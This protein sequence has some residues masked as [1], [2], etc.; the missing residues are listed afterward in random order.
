MKKLIKNL[1]KGKKQKIIT[2]EWPHGWYVTRVGRT[3][4]KDFGFIF[5]AIKGAYIKG[6]YSVS[7]P[8]LIWAQIPDDIKVTIANYGISYSNGVFSWD[9][10]ISASFIFERE[11]VIYKTKYL[12]FF[13]FRVPF[14]VKKKITIKGPDRI[15]GDLP[16]PIKLK[17]VFS[18]TD[19]Q[20]IFSMMDDQF[21]K[22]SP[23]RNQDDQN[24]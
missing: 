4:M 20:F 7:M 21:N 9:E 5:E 16:T 11:E 14:Q 23:I 6:K 22:F 24:L 18:M 10:K 13:F 12:N 3:E 8:R 2:N 1:F 17:D 19:D 15:T